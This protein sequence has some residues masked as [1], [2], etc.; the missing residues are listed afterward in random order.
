MA[1]WG[2]FDGKKAV[3]ASPVPTGRGGGWFTILEANSGDWQRN[4]EIDYD[5]V[6]AFHAVYACMTLIASDVAK[7]RVKLVRQDG[8]G[9]WSEIDNPAYS[10]VLR[11]PNQFQ[12]RIQFWEHYMLSKLSTGNAYVL[13][14]RDNRGV[15][16]ALHVLDP[17]RVTPLVTDLGDVYY[18]LAAD[19]LAGNLGDLVVP[20]S[21]IIHDRMNTI[22]HPLVGTSPIH[23]AGVAAMQ[24]LRI[25]TNATQFFANGA[26][27]GGILTAPGAISDET[28]HRLKSHWEANYSGA[29]AGRIAVLGDNLRFEAMTMTADDAQMIEQLKWTAAV[30]CSVFHVPLYKVAMGEGQPNYN[31][32][33]NLNVEYYS[34]CL[35][36]HIEAAELCLDEGLGLDAY[37]GDRIGTEFDLDGLLRM[38]SKTQMETLAEAKNLMTLNERRRRIDLPSMD[39]GDT[40]YLQEQDHS[41]EAIAARDAALVAGPPATLALPAPEPSQAEERAFVA[42]TLL[43]MR[44]AMEAA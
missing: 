29:N 28:A 27:P 7:L 2:L 1:F 26:R 10:P 3:S 38:D 9:V 43:S 14:R 17:R 18:Q 41:L 32:V 21:E 39:G 31:N 36:Q 5:G 8:S 19:N 6:R 25:Q 40:V 34:Q 16:T 11:K 35:Q 44:K 15:V 42:E 20:T 33:Q 12:N 4:V 24:G 30:V 37:V 23:A 22:Y 13:K